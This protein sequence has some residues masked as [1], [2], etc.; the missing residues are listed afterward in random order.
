MTDSSNSSPG[1]SKIFKW[2]DIPLK[3]DKK[4][5]NLFSYNPVA[6]FKFEFDT[7]SRFAG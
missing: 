7:N 6:N 2:V 4:E 1:N 5:I 3:S